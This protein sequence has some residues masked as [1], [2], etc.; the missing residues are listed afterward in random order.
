MKPYRGFRFDFSPAEAAAV[1]GGLAVDATGRVAMVAGED[2]VRQGILML[3]ST[4]RGERVMRP[5]YGCDLQ[6]LV[7]SP[8]DD[9]TA[10]LAIHYVREAL[11][12][13]E[14]RIEIERLDAIRHPDEP[15]LLIVVLAYR[16]RSTGRREH[17]ELPLDLSGG[18]RA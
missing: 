12:R 6:H 9:T 10:G 11:E 14:P 5:D 8:N 17:I 1:T 2:C 13:F 16:V 3:L 4:A 15:E 7:F 18:Q